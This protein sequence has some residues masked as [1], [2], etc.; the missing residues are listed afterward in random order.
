MGNRSN[1]FEARVRGRFGM[2]RDE[3]GRGRL[4]R[5][6]DGD[7]GSSTRLWTS[8]DRVGIGDD[9]ASKSASRN[10]Q[11]IKTKSLFLHYL[12]VRI[13]ESRLRLKMGPLCR[14]PT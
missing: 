7:D 8:R 5:R 4:A 13:G 10:G 14:N 12:I 9:A 6:R 3:L 11:K 1:G 2:G